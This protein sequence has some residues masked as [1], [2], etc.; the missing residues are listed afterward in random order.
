MTES[1]SNKAAQD[2]TE[3]MEKKM[4]NLQTTFQATSDQLVSRMDEMGTRIDNLE[5][6]VA[7]LM[8]QAGMEKPQ[9]SK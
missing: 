8:T 3:F 4:Q 1:N 2:L 7:D 9:T 6:N 5:K